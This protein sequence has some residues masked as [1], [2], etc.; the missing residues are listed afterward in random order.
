M[1]TNDQKLDIKKL[2]LE[3][4]YYKELKKEIQEK[5][6]EE[7]KRKIIEDLRVLAKWELKPFLKDQPNETIKY[8]E[9]FIFGP[10]N[11]KAIIEFKDKNEA[12]AITNPLT[13][14]Q[15][16]TNL[17]IRILAKYIADQISK[18]ITVMKISEKNEKNYKYKIIA[19]IPNPTTKIYMT[20]TINP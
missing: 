1:E 9:N 2:K 8:K 13:N 20:I 14:F 3:E 16:I 18:E 7:T 4:L 12:F 15:M 19:K 11:L 10:Y 17:P 5:E 6:F